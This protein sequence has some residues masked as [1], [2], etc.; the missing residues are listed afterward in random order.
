MPPETLARSAYTIRTPAF[1]GPFALLLELI[2]KRKLL[3][4]DL[5]LAQVTE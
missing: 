1:E 2:E 5:S 3:V 4:N